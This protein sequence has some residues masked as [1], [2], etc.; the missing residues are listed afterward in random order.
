MPIKGLVFNIQRFSVHDGP[1]IRTTV[2]LKGCPLQ[3]NWCHNPEGRKA[4]PEEVNGRQV[5]LW[6]DSHELMKELERDLI[7]YEDSG[8]G[9]TFSGGEPLSQAEFLAEMLGLCR[10]AGIHC[11]VD[12]SGYA[13]KS[14]FRRLLGKPDLYLYDIKLM[15]PILHLKYTGVSNAEILDNLKYLSHCKEQVIIRIPMIP[16]ITAT[17]KN[18]ED[19][20]RFLR[21]LGTITEVHLL[22]YHRLA[23]AKYRQFGVNPPVF[24]SHE[25]TPDEMEGY[26][27]LFISAG[28]KLNLTE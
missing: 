24:A 23:E 17:L 28:F 16:G 8:G 7:F 20:I 13:G 14:T 6:Y 11:A 19:I 21:G 27:S 22:P 5:G 2:F 12:T 3:C 4:V 9:V 25:I 15:D 18:L 10:E 1:G 26:R